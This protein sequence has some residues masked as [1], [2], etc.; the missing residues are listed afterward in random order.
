MFYLESESNNYFTKK[1]Q[2]PHNLSTFH[3]ETK[4]QNKL[5][6]IKIMNVLTHA[7]NPEECIPLE[8]QARDTLNESAFHS[9]CEKIAILQL[10][11]Y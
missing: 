5:I 2:K 1:C 4:M 11:V 6:D 3:I 9:V 10:N 7:L 8:P